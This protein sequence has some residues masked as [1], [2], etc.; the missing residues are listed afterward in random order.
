MTLISWSISQI[1]FNDDQ[2]TLDEM[3]DTFNEKTIHQQC[4]DRL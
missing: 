2:S 4:T 1:S 3:S